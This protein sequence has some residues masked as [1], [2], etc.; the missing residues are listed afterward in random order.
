MRLGEVGLMTRD[1]C[2]LADFYRFLLGIDERDDCPE[3]QI[4]IAQET[5]LTVCRDDEAA[6]FNAGLAFSVDD[7]D[8]EYQRM[9]ANGV[10]V[11]QPPKTQPWGA[12]NLII[13]DPDGNKVFLRRFL[14]PEA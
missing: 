13:L 7:V 2:R 14:Q 1:V 6:G 5:M 9:L 11:V 12:R 4:L 8:A 10:P 3:H